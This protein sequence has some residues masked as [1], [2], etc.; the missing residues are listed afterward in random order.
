MKLLGKSG[1]CKTKQVCKVYKSSFGFPFMEKLLVFT[2]APS[3]QTNKE[4]KEQNQRTETT[5]K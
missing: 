5:E 4:R 2:Y 1:G 3:I